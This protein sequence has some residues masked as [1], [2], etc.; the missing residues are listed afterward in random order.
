MPQLDPAW[1]PSQLFWLCV[2]F[3]TMLL[4]MG[5]IFAPRIA[6]ILA[7][8]QHKIDDYLVKANQIQ[9]QAEESLKKYH[10]ALAKATEDA[11]AAIELAHKELGEYI[12]KKQDDLTRKLNEKIKD[13]ET[14]INQEKEKAL[15]EVRG[16]SEEL[17]L[18]IVRKIGLS[19]IRAQDI[20]EAISKV[21][22]D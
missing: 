15:Q 1:Y 11:N 16:I 6:D 18:D 19:E 22:N 2:C 10:E 21:A 13:G 17:A 4:I 12:A 20:K 5:K 14:Q 7:Q 8:R 9:E 3:F